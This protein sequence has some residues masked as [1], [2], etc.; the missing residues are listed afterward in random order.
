LGGQ[1]DAAPPLPE[2]MTNRE[3][4]RPRQAVTGDTRQLGT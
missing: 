4:Y 3:V 2:P 1:H